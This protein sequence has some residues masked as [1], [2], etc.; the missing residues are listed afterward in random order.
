ML[1]F[2]SCPLY[3]FGVSSI[4]P[5]LSSAKTTVMF[6]LVTPADLKAGPANPAWIIVLPDLLPHL[7]W[8]V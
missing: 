2:G 6:A 1:T 8:S 7:Y 4:V 5:Q 3:N